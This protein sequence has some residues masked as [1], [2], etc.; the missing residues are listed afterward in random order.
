MRS[1]RRGLTLIELLVAMAIIAV[2]IGLLVPT[3]QRVREA[4]NRAACGN[5][6]KQLGLALHSYH[7]ANGCFTPGLTCSV[8]NVCDAEASGFTYL[9]P[10][11]EQ[12]NVYRLYHFDLPWYARENY[13]AVGLPAAVFFCPS[14]RDQGLLDLAPIAAQWNTPLPPVAATCDY[15]F[16]RGANGALHRDWTRIPLAVRGVF[17]IRPPD[18]ARP[19][20]R[21][22]D[23]SDGASTTFAMGEAV[24]GSPI[25]VVRDLTDPSRNVLDPASGQPIPLEQAWGAAGIGDSGHPWYGSV[26][27]VTAQYGLAPEPRD[28]PMNRRPGTP[29]VYGADL[30]GDG[31][32]GKDFISGFRSLHAGGGNFLFCDGSVR[33]V[34]SS[35]DPAVY[36]G[37]STYAGGETLSGENY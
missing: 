35:I 28:E 19:G 36:R 23:I 16:C 32:S 10:Y 29:T 14:N 8:T 21:L 37:L 6:L 17:N 34:A 5:N 9:L 27:A 22:T 33:F 11:L 7:A 25:Y 2:L 20:V 3:I 12:D 24:G 15:A 31:R 13:E 1:P 18:Q 4:A 30:R 26:F